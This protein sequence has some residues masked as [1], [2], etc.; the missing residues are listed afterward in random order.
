[1]ICCVVNLKH[2]Y[3]ITSED[4]TVY[5]I[6]LEDKFHS[7]FTYIRIPASYFVSKFHIRTIMKCSAEVNETQHGC[8]EVKQITHK[9]SIQLTILRL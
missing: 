4:K 6:W 7:L 8:G 9:G 5:Q 2:G 3:R 1:M